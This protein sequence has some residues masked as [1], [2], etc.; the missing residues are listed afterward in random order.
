M[1]NTSLIVSSSSWPRLSDV[2]PGGGVQLHGNWM[3]HRVPLLGDGSAHHVF[4]KS[5][6]ADAVWQNPRR[7]EKPPWSEAVTAD[8][9]FAPLVK[10]CANGQRFDAFGAGSEERSLYAGIGGD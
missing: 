9:R 8:Y 5:F 4:A 7:E 6:T 10:L 3:R 1:R 2:A